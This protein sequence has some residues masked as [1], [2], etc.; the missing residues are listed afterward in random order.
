MNFTVNSETNSVFV[1]NTLKSILKQL[2]S[3]V[4]FVIWNYY[5]AAQNDE[6]LKFKYCIYYMISEIY[7]TNINFNM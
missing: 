4:S 5:C 6:D 3:Q 1:F 7:F 2:K